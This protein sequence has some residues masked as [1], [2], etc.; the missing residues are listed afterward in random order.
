[1][2]L[3]EKLIA[4]DIE[5]TDSDYQKGSIIQI[6]AVIVNED[7]S[8]GAEFN[9]LIKPLDNYHN[10]DA[11]K[12][13]QITDEMLEN[14]PTIQDALD[15]F[16]KFAHTASPRPLLASWGNYFDITFIRETYRKIGRKYQFSYRSLDLKSIA[17]WE[18]AKHTPIHGE[19]LSGGVNAFLN[20][21][22]MQFEGT[23]HNALHDIKNTMRI[24]Q[25]L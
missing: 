11:R 25:A 5:S 2:K 16:E 15:A 22:G 19:G 24:I 10:P 7:L 17:I 1:M 18:M 13:H 8:L 4:L 3:P 20:A 21:L 9:T 14:A 12:V 23:P 6:G